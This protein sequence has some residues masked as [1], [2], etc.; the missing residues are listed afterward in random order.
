MMNNTQGPYVTALLCEKILEEKDGIKTAIRIIDRLTHVRV[1]PD[2]PAT[3][4]PF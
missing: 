2:A 1:G 3:L 4:P